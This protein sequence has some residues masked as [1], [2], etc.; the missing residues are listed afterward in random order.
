MIKFDLSN[1]FEAIKIKKSEDI[2]SN[3][4]K[5]NDNKKNTY[6]RPTPAISNIYKTEIP[7]VKVEKYEIQ[8]HIEFHKK[9]KKHIEELKA[10]LGQNVIDLSNVNNPD[11]GDCNYKFIEEGSKSLN[12]IEFNT[13]CGA[14]PEALDHRQVLKG[15]YKHVSGARPLNYLN[16]KSKNL[17]N[18]IDGS[19][20]DEEVNYIDYLNKRI[21]KIT[22]SNSIDNS[23]TDVN[24]NKYLNE[25]KQNKEY[26]ELHLLIDDLK[27]QKII[28][29]VYYIGGI[30]MITL[31][32]INQISCKKE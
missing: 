18:N 4:I 2:I 8:D 31:F 25:K 16:C 19:G 1:L 26:N 10:L 17:F 12:I 7:N 22:S 29:F 28:E 13:V 30:S 5:C 3:N 14:F 32:I 27:K 9:M 21:E 23:N 20:I 6:I 15:Y 11:D 24:I